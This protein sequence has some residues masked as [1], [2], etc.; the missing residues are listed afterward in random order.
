MNNKKEYDRQRYLSKKENGDYEK[1][2]TGPRLYNTC[3]FILQR[4]NQRWKETR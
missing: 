2:K 4:E 1:G 3:E